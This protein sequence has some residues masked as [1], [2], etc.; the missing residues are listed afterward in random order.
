MLFYGAGFQEKDYGVFV[1]MKVGSL[2]FVNKMFLTT[3]VI[4]SG[5]PGFCD[6]DEEYFYTAKYPTKRELQQFVETCYNSYSH[7]RKTQIYISA[8]PLR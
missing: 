4:L 3:I 1:Q 6:S 8:P 7:I 2:A 5:A